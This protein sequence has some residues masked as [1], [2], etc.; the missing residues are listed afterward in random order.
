MIV[1]ARHAPRENQEAAFR[2]WLIPYIPSDQAGE[3]DQE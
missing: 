3:T 2:K 1:D